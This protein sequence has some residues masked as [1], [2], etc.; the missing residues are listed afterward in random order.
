MLLNTTLWWVPSPASF[1]P[2]EISISAVT[3]K[4]T[5]SSDSAASVRSADGPAWYG[6]LDTVAFHCPLW[7]KCTVYCFSLHF[8]N[9][10][11]CFQ[12]SIGISI[13]FWKEAAGFA[14]FMT[15]QCQC[16]VCPC[17]VF[18]KYYTCVA[19]VLGDGGGCGLVIPDQYN[20]LCKLYFD[21]KAKNVML[22]LKSENFILEMSLYRIAELLPM[23]PLWRL[24]DKELQWVCKSTHIYAPASSQLSPWCTALCANEA[25]CPRRLPICMHSTSA[26]LLACAGIR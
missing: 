15:Y 20:Q 18:T 8:C 9:G 2:G 7:N 1:K 26:A 17:R 21:C 14:Q 23:Q 10:F 4:I 16:S 6:I 13:T 5:S 25:S 11:S 3:S 19:G 24:C 12:L 22:Y